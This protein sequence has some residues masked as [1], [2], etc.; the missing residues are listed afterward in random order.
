MQTASIIRHGLIVAAAILIGMVGT[1]AGLVAAVD[2]GYFRGAF[3]RFL[4]ARVG[5]PLEVHGKLEAHLFSLHPSVVAERVAIGNPPWMPSG[6]AAEAEKMSVVATLPRIGQA[7]GIVRLEM[8]GADFRLA[9]DSRGHANWQ[10]TDPDASDNTQSPILREVSIPNAHVA[11]QD[12]LRHLNFKGDISVR[13]THGED[14]SHALQIR[15]TGV[16]NG[17]E[18]SFEVTGDSLSSASHDSPYHF[19]FAEHSSGSRLTGHGFLSRPFDFD[20]LDASFDAAGEDLR[21][22]FYLTGVTLI[23]TGKYR[24]SGQVAR[25]GNHTRFSDL[26]AHSGQSDMQ[27]SL[28]IDSS[29]D[30]PKLGF[31]L[32]SQFLR[33]SDLGAR[34]AGRAADSEANPPLLLSDAALNQDTVR[35]DDATVIFH[36]HR[37]QVDRISL[38]GLS[39]KARMDHGVL[40]VAPLSADVL[41]G[42]LI[43]HATLDARRPIP[44]D[45]VDLKIRDL[46]L[47]QLGSQGNAPPPFEGSLQV[48]IAVN[49]HGSSVHQLAASANGTVT[50]V[51]PHGAMRESLAELTGIDL[52]G[53]GLL[54]GKSTQQADIRCGVAAFNAHNG[55]LTAQRIVLDTAPVLIVGEGEIHLDSEAL[56]LIFRGHPKSLRLFRLRSPLLLRG[57]LSRPTIDVGSR[58]AV[59]QVIDPGRA[60]DADCAALLAAADPHDEGTDAQPVLQ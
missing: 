53:L 46:Q 20:L 31:D 41:G 24:L 51:L 25:R 43:A 19:D 7:I 27:G 28:T 30:R 32:S 10:L 47:A 22:L 48:R 4:T 49:G 38:Y 8:Q 35:R 15:G 17:R 55:T 54:L 40:E 12:D 26:V 58:R 1:V 36:A 33:L 21:D 3:I 39:A 56:D 57:T 13:Q 59:L 9:R 6:L 60:K 37:L 14:S 16:L 29:G 2:A 11:L 23:D 34:A 18:A 5:R 44:A 45:E 52:R 42:K 50:V